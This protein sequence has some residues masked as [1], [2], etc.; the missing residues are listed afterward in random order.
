VGY[1]SGGQAPGNAITTAGRDALSEK[2]VPRPRNFQLGMK[3]GGGEYVA[4]KMVKQYKE[5]LNCD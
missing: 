4:A 5:N 3:V 2:S 1:G